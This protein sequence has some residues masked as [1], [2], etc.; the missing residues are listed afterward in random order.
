M[1]VEDHK[2][3]AEELYDSA[4]TE[5]PVDEPKQLARGYIRKELTE[6]WTESFHQDED[7]AKNLDQAVSRMR[8]LKLH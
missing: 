6:E 7:Y 5:K 4:N 3:V 8:K 2:T 1:S